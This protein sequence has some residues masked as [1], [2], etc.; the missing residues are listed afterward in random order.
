M[1]LGF[2]GL[3]VMGRAMALNL[4]RAGHALACWARR[5]AS[6]AP[7]VDAGAVPV[8][9][10]ADVARRSDVTFTVLPEAH[11]VEEVVLGPRGILEGAAPGSVV[12]D[13]STIAPLATRRIAA[14]L[15]TKGVEMLDAPVSR[16]EAAAV[17]GALAITVGGRPEVLERVRPLLECLGSSVVHVG[18]HGA[19]QVAKACHQ[20]VGAVTLEAVAEAMT[21]ARRNGADPAR[22]REALLGGFA[23]SRVLEDQGARMLR[24]DFAP[25]FEARLH[26][27]D[28]GIVLE[29]ARA[30]GLALPQSAL[31]AQ[32]LNALVGSGD[33][34]CDTAALV[35]VLERMAGDVRGRTAP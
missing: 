26:A 18:G 15:A 5:E 27:R 28:L 9:S 19:G 20:M 4:L 32:H 31:V 13:M 17:Q 30:L 1:N 23:W 21:L 10:V 35:K 14:R 12:V 24:H 6:L 16:G 3:G 7:I 2:V 22:V 29:T 8:A 33:G 11:D 25:G 34:G